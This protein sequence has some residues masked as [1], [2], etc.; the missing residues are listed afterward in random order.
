M[1]HQAY[2]CR[3]VMA[4]WSARRTPNNKILGWNTA[5]TTWLIKNRTVWATGDDKLWCLS[6]LCHK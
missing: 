5:V 2:I 4:E 6:S 3:V 1:F